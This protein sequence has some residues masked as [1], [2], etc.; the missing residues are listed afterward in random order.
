MW[1]VNVIHATRGATV[2]AY[3]VSQSQALIYIYRI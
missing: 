2:I 3:T 1:P